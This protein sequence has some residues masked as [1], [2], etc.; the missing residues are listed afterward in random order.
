MR[1]DACAFAGLVLSGGLDSTV[2]FWDTRSAS[3]A[4]VVQADGKVFAMATAR[5]MMV[6]ASSAATLA[7]YDL[8]QT[9]APVSVRESILKYQTR[10]LRC[11]PNGQGFVYG[12]TEGRVAVDFF[13]HQDSVRMSG[14]FARLPRACS[15]LCARARA[16]LEALR[17]QVPPRQHPRRRHDLRRERHRVPPD[18]RAKQ[19]PRARARRVLRGPD[20]T[21][22]CPRAGMARSP[23]AA[24]TRTFV[25]G[26]ATPRSAW[27]R[28][29]AIPSP[30]RRCAS[31]PWARSWRSPRRTR[32]TRAHSGALSIARALQLFGCSR[33][34]ACSNMPRDT[35]FVRNLQPDDVRSRAPNAPRP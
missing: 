2:R 6:V 7:V 27:A 14:A 32:S 18:V 30:Y 34:P 35:V 22:A 26:T 28:Q 13:D 9:A 23:R 16:D 17:V 21:A 5:Q 1:A 12:S 4:G 10:S 8:R 19:A 25:S 24:R 33:A 11:M 31:T 15:L 3:E 20:E 29:C